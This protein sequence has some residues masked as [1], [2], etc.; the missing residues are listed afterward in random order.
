MPG[1]NELLIMINKLRDLNARLN[2][3][4]KIFQQDL[5]NSFPISV[6]L[7]TG[8]KCNLKC[9]FCTDRVSKEDYKN[10]SF[11]EF[12]K[13]TEPLNFASSIQIQG[14]GEPLFNPDY[15]KILDF[16]IMK[17]K[18]ARIS[19]NTNGILLDEE[20]NDKFT[21]NEN[22]FV[23]ISVNGSTRETYHRVMGVDHFDKVIRN[24]QSLMEKKKEKKSLSP[25]VS[26]SFVCLENNIHELPGFINLAADL[27]INCVIL[28][29]LMILRKE[30]EKYVP[31]GRKV[32]GI[33]L[34]ALENAKKRGVILDT[35]SFPVSNFLDENAEK[36]E[37]S[38]GYDYPEYYQT[39]DFK[40]Y[41]KEC[42]DPWTYFQVDTDGY[43]KICCF[44]DSIVGNIFMQSF[45]DIWNGEGYRYYRRN[46]NTS[47]PPEDCVRCVKKR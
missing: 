8:D 35:S 15:G 32:K 6:G 42:R 46:V 45:S 27:G 37:E 7:P 25:F 14:W 34:Q 2:F 22:I 12:L 4:E 5:L 31:H 20:W 16:V 47:A 41:F 33:L 40:Y 18:G 38:K 19:F 21:S 26:L 3:F 36:I 29:E 39:C 10:I 13:F 17:C 28:R 30:H 1:Q 43:V 24:I 44:S 11:E 23:N 9:V